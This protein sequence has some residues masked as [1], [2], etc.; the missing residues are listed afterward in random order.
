[1]TVAA[2]KTPP[3]LGNPLLETVQASQ[4]QLGKAVGDLQQEVQSARDDIG[5]VRA[6]V[7]DL[8]LAHTSR[9][10]LID[11]LVVESRRHTLVL[12]AIARKLG[13]VVG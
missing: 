9:D 2:Q 13:V 12:D 1:M 7:S 3:Y 4:K 6:I 5:V 8:A 11:E 10:A